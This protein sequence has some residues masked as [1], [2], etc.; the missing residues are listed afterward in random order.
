[1]KS[2]LTLFAALL[3]APSAGQTAETPLGDAAAVWHFG[4][5][6]DSQQRHPL[7]VHGAVQLGVALAGEERAASLAR[8]RWEGGAV[9]RRP[10]GDRRA[11]V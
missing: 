10:S 8:G 1:M 9:R 4:D 11:G 5:A 2:V 3:L 6:K 7:I